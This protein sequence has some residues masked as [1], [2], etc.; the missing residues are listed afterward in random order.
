MNHCDVRR[1]GE[2]ERERQQEREREREGGWVR[3]RAR[4]E[5]EKVRGEASCPRVIFSAVLTRG[6]YEELRAPLPSYTLALIASLL[7]S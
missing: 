1:E 4:E 7:C 6:P 3:E 5:R 2:R